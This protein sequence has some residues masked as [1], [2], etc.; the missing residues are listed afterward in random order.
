[1]K[2]K[3]RL[4]FLGESRRRGWSAF[5]AVYQRASLPVSLLALVGIGASY[6]F[7]AWSQLGEAVG[8]AVGVFLLE[9]AYRAWDTHAPSELTPEEYGRQFREAFVFVQ[10]SL[11]VAVKYVLAHSNVTPP[12]EL[13]VPELHL[14]PLQDNRGERR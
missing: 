1:M 10:K 13:Q 9:G 5:L 11:D 4:Q 12:P 6:H 2:A 7:G 3:G 8:V 14:P